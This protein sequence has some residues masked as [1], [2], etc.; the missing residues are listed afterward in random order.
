MSAKKYL[1]LLFDYGDVIYRN[2]RVLEL[3]DVLYP[4]ELD[5]IAYK[6]GN[7]LV[8]VYLQSS[9]GLIT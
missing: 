4:F 1:L 8:Y 5:I 9:V 2:A 7:S 3:L 6:T